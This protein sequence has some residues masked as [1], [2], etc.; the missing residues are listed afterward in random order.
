[1]QHE[2][3]VILR[4]FFTPIEDKSGLTIPQEVFQLIDHIASCKQLQAF[5]GSKVLHIKSDQGRELVSQ[6][7][8]RLARLRGIHL[9]PS[10]AHQP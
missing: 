2:N 6:D 7:F 9:S 5:H 1:M 10:L 8:K 4:A 3:K